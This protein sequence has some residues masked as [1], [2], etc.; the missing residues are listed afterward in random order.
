MATLKDIA[1]ATNLSISTV[2]RV[3]SG[4]A[5]QIGIAEETQKRVLGS[6]QAKLPAHM[7]ARNLKLGYQPKCV[8]FSTCK[9]RGYGPKSFGAS[10]LHHRPVSSKG[11]RK[12]GLLPRIFG[13]TEERPGP[14][15]AASWADGRLKPLEPYPDHWDEL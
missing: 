13:A 9:R 5:D 1:E 6:R 2:S 8:L 10:I 3:L 4:T 11:S 14:A 12:Q 15:R 7:A